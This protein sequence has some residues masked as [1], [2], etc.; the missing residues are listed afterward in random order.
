MSS[1]SKTS[2]EKKKCLF[3]PSEYL[4][5]QHCNRHMRMKHGYQKKEPE[6]NVECM[7]CPRKYKN[8]VDCDRHM[9]ANHDY[10]AVAIRQKER[11][12][13]YLIKW[14]E[15]H[16]KREEKA[17]LKAEKDHIKAEEAI[18]MKEEK[19]RLKTENNRIKAEEAR[20]LKEEKQKKEEEQ[21]AAK[22][23]K[24]EEADVNAKK[25]K[26][27]RQQEKEEKKA[28]KEKQREEIEAGSLS[29]DFNRD[30]LGGAI[31]CGKCNKPFTSNEERDKHEEKHDDPKNFMCRKCNKTFKKMDN[32]DMHEK[33]CGKEVKNKPRNVAEDDNEEDEEVFSLNQSALGGVAKVYR[34]TFAKGIR[35]L[36]PRLQRAMDE[37]SDELFTLQRNNEMVRYYVS[38]YCTFYKPTDP[39]SITDPPVV[40]NSGR[41]SLLAT[42]NI[43]GEMEINYEN[44][45]HSIEQYERNGSGWC[46]LRLD[47]L[48]MNVIRYNPLKAAY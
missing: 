9:K 17:T 41:S 44:I 5:Q 21:K 43:N 14:G 6:D 2:F 40:F 10:D 16:A 42:S 37:A 25:I 24:M 35:N 4:Q 39:D 23:R 45:L 28:A 29:F 7:F 13:K 1:L 31:F 46:L 26:I 20:V 3:C 47:A 33:R 8:R 30:V 19:A 36:H 12:E 34:L 27:A 22:K 11:E 32:K 18:I 38:L 15:A 48:D